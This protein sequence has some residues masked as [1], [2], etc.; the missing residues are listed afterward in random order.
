[1]TI[2]KDG[3]GTGKTL[4]IDNTNRA[5]THAVTISETTEAVNKG[6]AYNINT[7]NIGL[8]SQTESAILYFKNNEDVDVEL[9]AFAVGVDSA[10]TTGN[11]SLVTLIR[12]PTAGT[13]IDNATAVAMNENRNF[14]SS[15]ILYG[16]RIKIVCRHKLYHP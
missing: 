11:D 14:G 8:T 5:D 12:N 13:I 2:I 15:T 9:E 10:G 6:D 1:M 3:A 16:C 4:R 7:G